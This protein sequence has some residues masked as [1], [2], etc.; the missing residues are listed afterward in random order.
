MREGADIDAF[1]FPQLPEDLERLKNGAPVLD[2]RSRR[3]IE[4][5]RYLLFETQFGRAHRETGRHIDLLIW[6][7]TPLDVALARNMQVFVSAALDSAGTDE[8]GNRLRWMQGYLANYLGTVRAL[9][10][11]QAE[12]VRAQADLILDGQQ[13]PNTLARLAQDEIRR[14][15]P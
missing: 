13:E 10:V 7:D 6:I 11:M 9:L 8:T 1:D 12:R 15:F 2:P 4:P 14:R 3:P 5:Q